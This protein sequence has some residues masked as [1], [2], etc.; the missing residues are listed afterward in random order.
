M[1]YGSLYF[2]QSTLPQYSGCAFSHIIVVIAQRMNEPE[3]GPL[4]AD[5]TERIDCRPAHEKVVIIQRLDKFHGC[6]NVHYVPQHVSR[7]V[8]RCHAIEPTLCTHTL[9]CLL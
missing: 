9:R 1:N 3:H 4:A 8:Q 2:L 7:C 6:P 5:P